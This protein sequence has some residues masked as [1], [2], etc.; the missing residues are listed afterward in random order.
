[1][2]FGSPPQRNLQPGVTVEQATD[3]AVEV[4]RAAMPV[5]EDCEV[6]LAVEPLAPAETDF[7]TTTG[8]LTLSS[9]SVSRF[10]RNTT[11][12]APQSIPSGLST[13][14]MLRFGRQERCL[15][16]GPVDVSAPNG[17]Q[18]ADPGDSFIRLRRGR[19]RCRG[20]RAG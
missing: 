8:L 5:L 12:G 2:V 19:G 10:G 15:E 17:L 14:A 3:H 7:L 13:N 9:Q 11:T 1:M 16:Q 6:T 18:S 4:F 20:A